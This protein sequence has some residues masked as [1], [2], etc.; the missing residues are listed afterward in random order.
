MGGK[1]VTTE[2]YMKEVEDIH[3]G[4]GYEY[5]PGWEYT[6]SKCAIC[7]KCPEHGWW[8]TKAYSH[9]N[10]K[11]GC[12]TCAEDIHKE[13]CERL[14][15]DKRARD[16]TSL[17]KRHEERDD[18]VIQKIAEKYGN[19][20]EILSECVPEGCY[21]YVQCR[22]HNYK[23]FR[24]T[25]QLYKSKGC[26]EC[27]EEAM[28]ENISRLTMSQEDIL[29]RFREVHGDRYDYSRVNYINSVEKVEVVCREHGSFWIKPANHTHMKSGCASCAKHGF[30]Q[31]KP[32]NLYYIKIP[33]E[34]GN[35]YKIGVTNNTVKK[36]F[37]RDDG[38]YVVLKEW[39][40]EI[41]SDAYG[42]EQDIL[43]RYSKYVGCPEDFEW[44]SSGQTEMFVCDVLRL[45]NSM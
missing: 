27:G 23:Y 3:T 13:R 15:W 12:P 19:E 38:R 4:K 39:W 18:Y 35:Y 5:E 8:T 33:T 24:K 32:G 31:N 16:N 29:E 22:K 1:R 43:R 2:I 30:D 44:Y 41:G 37:C 11:S 34:F 36:R 21:I 6:G 10:M 26:Q 45:D 25:Q 20:I 28:Q 9:R 7:I 40:Y 42:E 14:K 17:Y